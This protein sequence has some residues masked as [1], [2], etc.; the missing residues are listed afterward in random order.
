MPYYV[1]NKHGF[2]IV[3]GPLSS[4]DKAKEAKDRISIRKLGAHFMIHVE[5]EAKDAD[6]IE[7]ENSVRSCP[8]SEG[9]GATGD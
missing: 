1:V 4:E 2:E 6:D 8:A 7:S 9:N 5:K 3:A